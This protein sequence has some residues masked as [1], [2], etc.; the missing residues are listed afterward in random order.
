MNVFI[1]WSGERSKM[2][3]QLL[4]DWLKCVLQAT[5]PWL[6]GDN[7]ERGAMWFPN[8]AESLGKCNI[9]IICL[10]KE[11][12][13]APWILFEAGGLLKGLS[14]DRVCTLLVDLEPKD[15][16]PPLSQFNHTL[17]T[18]ESMFQLVTTLNNRL[19]NGKLDDKTLEKVFQTYWPMFQEELKGILDVSIPP[20]G[21]VAGRSESELLTE[22]LYTVRSLEQQMKRPSATGSDWPFEEDFPIAPLEEPDKFGRT[23]KFEKGDRIVHK[24][25]G[26]G[27]VDGVCRVG[28]DYMLTV[29]FDDVGI[30]RIMCNDAVSKNLLV[31]ADT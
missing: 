24:I 16:E 11:N 28:K 8:I 23:V 1:S 30:K 27:R 14:S 15:I 17:P 2:V 25:F 6:S 29:Y 31:K 13:S 26:P 4:K 10:T 22:I 7:I 3:A 19:E 20:K 21:T 12:R 9:G 18:Y 5:E